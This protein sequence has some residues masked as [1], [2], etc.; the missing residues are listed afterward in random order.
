MESVP[1]SPTSSRP[2]SRDTGFPESFCGRKYAVSLFP[3]PYLADPEQ[4]YYNEL[5][6][7]LLYT[8]RNTSLPHPDADQS[9]N[10][11]IWADDLSSLTKSQSRNRRMFAKHHRTIS[12]G[13]LAPELMYS[14]M[15]PLSE[16]ASLASTTD[17]TKEGNG[18]RPSKDESDS[19]NSSGGCDSPGEPKDSHQGIR[20]Y[21]GQEKHAKR[22]SFIGRWLHK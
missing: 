14:D 5:Y 2:R 13:R 7:D 20:D 19:S 12:H 22:R 8:D 10:A 11:T 16:V 17:V 15:R 6:A 1:E 9:P 21:H 4:S 18:G 3:F